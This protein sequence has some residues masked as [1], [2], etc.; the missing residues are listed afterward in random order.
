LI[1]NEKSILSGVV[2]KIVRSAD[3]KEFENGK[4]LIKEVKEWFNWYNHER[5]HQS[6]EYQTPN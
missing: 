1:T 4:E 2:L 5:P 6:L 3:I